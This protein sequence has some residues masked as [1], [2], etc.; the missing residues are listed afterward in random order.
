LYETTRFGSSGRID[1][2][3]PN[4]TL[5]FASVIKPS[6]CQILAAFSRIAAIN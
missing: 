2:S 6:S 5:L 1:E 3:Y 4:W